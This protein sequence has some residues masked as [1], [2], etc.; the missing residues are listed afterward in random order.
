MFCPFSFGGGGYGGGRGGRGGG[1]SFGSSF[2]GGGGGGGGFGKKDKLNNQPGQFLRKPK[3]DLNAMPKIKKDFYREHPN[4]QNR[5]MV[6]LWFKKGYPFEAVINS[7]NKIL[8]NKIMD[9]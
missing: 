7:K 2:R 8:K 5:S 6:S 4:S 1:G 3:W 9:S